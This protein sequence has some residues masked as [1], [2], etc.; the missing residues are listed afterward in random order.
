MQE[1]KTDFEDFV[2]DFDIEMDFLANKATF[3]TGYKAE[4][5]ELVR[6]GVN[7]RSDGDVFLRS[8]FR[9]P[10]FCQVGAKDIGV[11]DQIGKIVDNSDF[12][13]PLALFDTY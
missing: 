13:Q 10:S 7:R 11:V 1:F 9:P 2:K 4:Y 3:E 5:G 12:S 6:E 8:D